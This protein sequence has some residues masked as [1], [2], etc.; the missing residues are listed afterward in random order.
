MVALPAD[1]CPYAR[2]TASMASSME[3]AE[4]MS[5]AV[6]IRIC[7]VNAPLVVKLIQLVGFIACIGGVGLVYVSGQKMDV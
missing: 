6:R 2:A 7:M 1:N 4:Q 3:S 5:A